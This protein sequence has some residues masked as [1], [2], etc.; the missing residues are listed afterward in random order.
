LDVKKWFNIPKHN[1]RS[2][3]FWFGV[4]KYFEGLSPAEGMAIRI[5]DIL[6]FHLFPEK[7]IIAGLATWEVFIGIGLLLNVFML[8]TL[9]LLFL[10]MLG[11]FA[12][13][14]LFPS[15]RF[16]VYPVA[17]TLERQYIFKNIVLIS[18][19]IVLGATVRGGKLTL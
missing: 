9:L 4:L 16:H 6:T 11:T 3:L 12:P 15:E 19:G 10:Q 7:I 14:V 1:H 17:L 8:K 18:A 2:Y 13:L 5:I